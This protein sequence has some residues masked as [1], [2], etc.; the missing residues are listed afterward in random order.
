[1][2]K[3][4]KQVL[5]IQYTV[6]SD[7]VALDSAIDK[8]I[9]DSKTLQQRIQDVSVGILLHAFHTGDWRK[10]N[11]LVKG[12]ADGVR[13]EALVDWF[14]KFGGLEVSEAD[15]QFVGFKGPE[16]I[17]ANMD[18]A[19]AT[20]WWTLRKVNPFAG[21]DLDAELAK[22]LKKHE[23]AVKKAQELVNKGDAEAMD[24][25]AAD[26]NKLNAIHNLLRIPS[27]GSETSQDSLQE[28]TPSI[29]LP[30]AS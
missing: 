7:A 25:V 27:T 2:S 30:L 11:D 10:A 20:A 14:V 1:M 21:F 23:R 24:K 4:T 22:L 9:R 16:H 12:L 26:D 8:I 19:K 3:Q 18:D 5:N 29:D 13:K 28:A 6:F 15:E 17:K